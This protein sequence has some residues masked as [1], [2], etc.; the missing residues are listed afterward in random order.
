MVKIIRMPFKGSYKHSQD[1]GARP[2]A[3]KKYGLDGHDGDDF[4]MGQNTQIISPVNGRVKKRG[5]DPSGWGLYIQIWDW[6]QS[7]LVNLTHMSDIN[8]HVGDVVRVGD[9]VARSGDSGNSSAPH[10]HI[11]VADTGAD[12]KRLNIDNGFKGWYSIYDRKRI[13]IF[14]GTEYPSRDS[15]IPNHM[16][17]SGVDGWM[18]LVTDKL[19]AILKKLKT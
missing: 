18:I 14:V 4:L 10:L 8:L 11:A 7:L 3:Y 13:Q 6:E 9:E 5:S 12:G 1:F 17:V 19:D 15:L 16:Q 2:E